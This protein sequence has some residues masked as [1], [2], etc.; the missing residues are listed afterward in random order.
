MNPGRG[1]AA[2]VDLWITL[3]GQGD[4]K[5]H[6]CLDNAKAALPTYPQPLLLQKIFIFLN[7]KDPMDLKY[8]RDSKNNGDIERLSSRKEIGG[9]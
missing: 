5:L 8:L 2:G 7:I 6:T 3:Q 1:Y 9:A 4:H